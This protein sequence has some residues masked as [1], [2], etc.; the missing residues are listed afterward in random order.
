[1]KFIFSTKKGE[2][3]LWLLIVFS[4][5]VVIAA[6]VVWL[7][8]YYYQDAKREKVY[9]NILWDIHTPLSELKEIGLCKT[10][11]FATVKYFPLTDTYKLTCDNQLG[12]NL[13][14]LRFASLRIISGCTATDTQCEYKFA[15]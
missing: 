8:F 10:S 15:K 6:G 4:V 13:K 12:E 11:T 9:L 5:T 3:Q 14:D 7:L 2:V 1:M